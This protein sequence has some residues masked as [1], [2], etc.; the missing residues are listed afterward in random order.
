MIH[1][2]LRKMYCKDDTMNTNQFIK[3][4][5]GISMQK[6]KIWMKLL[7][8]ILAV[9]VFLTTQEIPVF[10]DVDLSNV[11]VTESIT[12]CRNGQAN[13][14]VNLPD[15][16]PSDSVTISYAF[17]DGAATDVVDL[18]AYTGFLKAQ[19]SGT[20]IIVTTIKVVSDK[21]IQ[22]TM[23]TLVKVLEPADI[24][25]Q[26]EKVDVTE[27]MELKIGYKDQ[28]QITYP[29][30]L[31]DSDVTVSFAVK[32]GATED[33]AEVDENGFVKGLRAG[34]TTIVTTMVLK[35]DDTVK[36]TGETTI[37]VIN[38]AE[39]LNQLEKID[40]PEK[41]ILQKE[42]SRKIE[43]G[44]PEGLSQSDV[45][46][47]FFIKEGEDVAQ[48]DDQGV[49]S[50]LKAGTAMI[51]TTMISVL[52]SSVQKTAETEV[53][54]FAKPQYNS[55][56]NKMVWEYVYFGSY[57]QSEVSKEEL[58]NEIIE[59]NY[60]ESEDAWVNG[61][62]YR[63]VQVTEGYRYFRWEQIKWK[64]L[65]VEENNFILLADQ[66]IYCGP[67]YEDFNTYMD[68]GWKSCSIRTWMN[69]TFYKEAFSRDE[70]DIIINKEMATNHY[71]SDASMNKIFTKDNV[72]LLSND[73]LIS[74]YGLN[75]DDYR[76]VS[77]SEYALTK[78]DGSMEHECQDWWLRT[79]YNRVSAFGI[80]NNGSIS[81]YYFNSSIAYVPC[82]TINACSDSWY[83]ENTVNRLEDQEIQ[84]GEETRFRISI[85]GGDMSAY[86]Y[87]WYYASDF[88]EEGTMIN[89]A[90]SYFYTIPSVNKYDAGYYYCE[91]NDGSTIIR[92]N[93]AKLSVYAPFKTSLVEDQHV[94]LGNDAVF[95][96]KASGGKATDYTYQWYWAQNSLDEATLIKG[97]VSSD[98]IIPAR[99]VTSGLNGYFFYCVVS[100]GDQTITTNKAKL[101][102][103]ES[104]ASLEI[105]M[106]KNKSV[107]KGTSVTFQVEVSGGNY[108]NYNYQW[109]FSMSEKAKGELIKGA[110]SNNYTIPSSNVTEELNG[111]YY[112]CLVK[113]GR[114][115]KESGRAKLTVWYPPSISG[116][117][118]MSAQAGTSVTFKVE[119]KGGNPSKCTYQWY[120]ATSLKANGYKIPGA[121]SSSYTIPGSEVKKNMDGRYYY[122]MVSNG[123]YSV[124]S[125][126]AKLKIK[127]QAVKN[128]SVKLHAFDEVKVSWKK[129]NGVDGYYVYRSNSK[130]GKY[131]RIATVK[132]T[133]YLDKKLKGK[134]VYFYKVAAFKGKS[135]GV[136]SA[137]KS[138]KIGGRVSTPIMQFTRNESKNTFTIS[139]NKI[140]NATKMEIW[141]KVDE[142]GQ[143][144][145][146]KTVSAKRT[147]VTYSY[148]SF[149]PGHTY[150]F[151]IRAF[152][153]N[154]VPIYSFYSK[155][156]GMML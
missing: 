87:Q 53:K 54:V 149:A 70:K 57:P 156:Y 43:V 74:S 8:M 84:E 138:K 152:Y 37:K 19:K 151:K 108:E 30:G 20:T 58:T 142:N 150:F 59:A 109:Y 67:Y 5:E 104:G 112:Y 10:A 12:M 79:P 97:A 38:Q 15:E 124:T 28:I 47:N 100:N 45:E 92:T 127:I 111:R 136:Q 71:L 89:G 9:I 105:S 137:A 96:V 83:F 128:L 27:S 72:Y 115:K 102:I 40:V 75:E 62:K 49:I 120:L 24:L 26:A 23:E 34:I 141:S 2:V 155:G 51:V 110:V 63:R 14:Q 66:G 21:P 103:S 130:N 132:G 1:N 55:E 18:D 41:L 146:W 73:D 133:S 64:L 82:I 88:E 3:K 135:T 13:I 56:I 25:G 90:V 69:D 35:T 65:D 107:K 44:I 98:Y 119:K 121:V 91:V 81:E 114:E 106:P 7:S 52:D 140:R 86:T 118:N 42:L 76:R 29:E 143:Y 94:K 131:N 129:I 17:K 99:E 36:K 39:I 77:C 116:P 148:K 4:W 154:D 85:G 93:R 147:S 95:S 48:V 113:D 33:V 78:Y 32:E 60:N 122:C 80:D 46:L 22:K 125:K 123:K 68:L 126:R 61:T 139:W 11:T 145:K 6:K 153:V 144:K 101:T 31:F 16:V 117:K 50:G 134:R